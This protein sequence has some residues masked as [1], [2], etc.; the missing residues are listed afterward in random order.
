MALRDQPYLPLYVQDFLTDEKLNECSAKSVGVYIKIMCVMHKSDDYG[1][2][3]L[4]QK[5]K[6]G[7]NNIEN[8]S[9]K[10]TKHLPFSKIIIEESIKEL[11]DEKVLYIDNDMLCQKRMIKDNGLSLLRSE[12]G[13]IG[14]KKTQFANKLG[15]ANIKAKAKAKEQPNTEYEIEYVNELI[16]NAWIKFKDYKKTQFNFNYKSV[17]SEQIAINDFVKLCNNNYDNAD[18]IINQTIV[19]GWKGLFELKE[20]NTSEKIKAPVIK[21][22]TEIR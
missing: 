13:K 15:K 8:F 19:N 14:G 21:E 3:L 20:N 16:K 17:K 18:K 2:I 9:L 11:I 12:I 1:K 6:I 5:D 7:A 22:Q 4:K 10:L